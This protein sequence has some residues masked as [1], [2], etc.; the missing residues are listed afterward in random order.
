MEFLGNLQFPGLKPEHRFSSF[1][2]PLLFA[3]DCVRCF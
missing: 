2:N 1:P 3:P